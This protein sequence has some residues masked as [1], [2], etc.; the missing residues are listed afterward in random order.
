MTSHK[1]TRKPIDGPSSGSQ[2]S[3]N[4]TQHS[5]SRGSPIPIDDASKICKAG[6]RLV[7]RRNESGQPGP[8]H[9]SSR[10]TIGALPDNVLLDIFDFYHRGT[11]NRDFYRNQWPWPWNRL[12][13][14]CQRWRCVVFASPLRLDLCLRCTSK[15]SVRETLDVWPP[16]PIEI[17]LGDPY[18]VDNVIAALEHCERVRQIQIL[19]LTSSRLVTMMQEPFPA[20]TWLRLQTSEAAPTLPDMFLGGSASRLEALFLGGIP[21]PGLPRLLLT[22]SDLSSLS[23]EGIP[24]TGYISPGAMVTGLSAL[25]RLTRLSIKFESPASRPDRRPP[26]PPRVILP[27]LIVLEFRG[28]SEYLE[29]LVARIGAPQLDTLQISLF[30]QLIFDIQQLPYFIDHAGMFREYNRAEVIFYRGNVEI[31]LRPPEVAQ[32]TFPYQKLTLGI[33]CNEVDWQVSCM[34]EISQSFFLLSSVEELDIQHD[35]DEFDWGSTWQAETDEVPWLELFRPFIAVQTLRMSSKP[36]SLIV[37][38]LQQRAM[39]VLPALKGLYLEEYQPSGSGSDQ[40]AIGLF[41]AARQYSDHP[42]TV[43]LWEGSEGSEWEGSES[44]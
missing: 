20:L 25:T 9:I 24:H 16:L 18:G 5:S 40:Q 17:S 27:A 19:N 36:Q 22:A 6:R 15:T 43:D 26:P 12:V 11:E 32:L 13:H 44:E 1:R 29:D 14:V 10:V 28:V 4:I 34:A 2:T 42:V 3:A 30:N 31:V 23:L 7:R 37:P 38:A 35:S 39:E 21:F 8:D 33:L 41:I